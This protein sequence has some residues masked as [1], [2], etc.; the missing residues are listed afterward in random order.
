MFAAVFAAAFMA[1][2]HRLNAPYTWRSGLA[3]FATIKQQMLHGTPQRRIAFVLLFIVSFLLLWPPPLRS[4]ARLMPIVGVTAAWLGW[5]A[6]SI[7]WSTN[8]FLSL[9]CL[10]SWIITA[11]VGF[12]TGAEV[13]ADQCVIII[14]LVCS[15]FLIAG[16]GNELLNSRR[17]RQADYRFAGTLHPNHQALSCAM[18]AFSFCWLGSAGRMSV[19]IATV[20]TA[21]GIVGLGLT[22]SR[23]AFWAA[24]TATV[25]WIAITP[26]GS[27]RIWPVGLAVGIFVTGFA[28]NRLI[29]KA[30][31]EGG[32]SRLVSTLVL[33]GRNRHANT[34]NRRTLLWKQVIPDTARNWILGHGFGAFWDVRRLESIRAKTGMIVC[35]CHSTPVE[36]FVR[37]GVIGA[38]LFAAT[39]LVAIVAALGL[40]AAAGTF[41]VSIFVFMFADGILESFLA[42]PSF[43]SCFLFL[44]L[45]ALA[46]G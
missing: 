15:A 17:N 5:E 6:S 44:L 29:S 27:S 3:N 34:L 39:S 35:S 43:N 33:L 23:T 2:D 20:C 31:T 36:I 21:A 7:L 30:S 38:A 22:R 1:I 4:E 12:V 28:V 25:T 37:S 19:E 40:H 9:Q 26:P 32:R 14:A 18:L 42:V 41:L 16:I 8:M 45:G 11:G 24:E 46:A 13:G 10:V